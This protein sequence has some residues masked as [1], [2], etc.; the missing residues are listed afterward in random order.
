MMPRHG[1]GRD[2]QR[3]GA[4][5]IGGATALELFRRKDLV[6]L[7]ESSERVSAYTLASRIA[8]PTQRWAAQLLEVF[9]CSAPLCC[10]VTRAAS[11]RRGPVRSQLLKPLLEG[12]LLRLDQGVYLLSPELLYLQMARGK[13][14]AQLWMLASELTARYGIDART[15]A[16]VQPVHEAPSFMSGGAD[17]NGA[18]GAAC[19][20]AVLDE[21]VRENMSPLFERSPLTTPEALRAMA[22]KAGHGSRS[23]ANRVAS[24]V[25]GGARSPKEAQL[26]ALLAL[27]RRLGGRGIGDMELNHIFDLPRRAQVIAGRRSVEG[28]LYISSIRRSIEYDSERHHADAEQRELDI[29]KA[30]ALRSIGVDVRTITK[31]QLYTWHLF[32]A[33]ADSISE[34]AV[35]PRSASASLATRQYKLWRDL[36]FRD[37]GR[38]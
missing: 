37:E 15:E 10:V 5:V 36:L 16:L 1:D 12:E 34:D 27:P 26:A 2:I 30:N 3:P 14:M 18:E 9:G 29:R 23:L 31:T 20:P 11:R 24:L 35:G 25:L 4:V 33:L 38:A 28:D 6:P 8:A 7:I 22:E 19:E 32:N 21:P 13:D 17:R